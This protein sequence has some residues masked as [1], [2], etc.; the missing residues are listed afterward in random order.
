MFTF[1]FCEIKKHSS[2][3]LEHLRRSC[4][5]IRVHLCQIQFQSINKAIFYVT[6]G[7]QDN[8]GLHRNEIEKVRNK[9]VHLPKEISLVK[10]VS[11]ICDQERQWSLWPFSECISD[12][13]LYYC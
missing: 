2:I 3:P 9:Q 12:L 5:S 10:K 7:S 11:T 13:K 4:T 6:E 8:N 1:M